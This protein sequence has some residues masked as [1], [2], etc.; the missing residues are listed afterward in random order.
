MICVERRASR[1]AIREEWKMGEGKG[2]GVIGRTGLGDV[3][4]GRV[5]WRVASNRRLR[6]ICRELL[7]P[8]YPPER[9]EG[10]SLCISVEVSG[11]SAR[12]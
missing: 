2:E 6:R 3:R 10:M 5:W 4:A 1:R 12:F 7:Y 11:P 8:S 9:C